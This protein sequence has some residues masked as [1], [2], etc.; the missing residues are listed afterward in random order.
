MSWGLFIFIVRRLQ[1]L[2]QLK[3]GNKVLFHL[4]E[5]LIKRYLAD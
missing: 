1:A 4:C 2:K 3:N 5:L